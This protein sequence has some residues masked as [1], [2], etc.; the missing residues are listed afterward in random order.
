MLFRVIAREGLGVKIGGAKGDSGVRDICNNV[1]NL[2]K[3]YIILNI[4]SSWSMNH[5]L[6]S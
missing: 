1:N 3:R 5:C 6:Q 2:K 4:N